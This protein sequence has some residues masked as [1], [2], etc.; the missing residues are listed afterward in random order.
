[1]LYRFHVCWDSILHLQ[2]VADEHRHEVEP[3]PC[4]VSGV[5]VRTPNDPSTT[6]PRL[7]HYS[8]AACSIGKIVTVTYRVDIACMPA[9]PSLS[10]IEALSDNSQ[11]MVIV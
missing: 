8:T 1:M 4:H 2:G 11:G 7:T 9:F 3:Y 10:D 6:Q 5:I